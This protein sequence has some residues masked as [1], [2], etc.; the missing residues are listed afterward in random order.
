[1]MKSL[2]FFACGGH[3]LGHMTYK[4]TLQS[5]F[6]EFIPKLPLI[7]AFIAKSLLGYLGAEILKIFRLRRAFTGQYD[8][9]ACTS[10]PVFEFI[11]KLP[12]I[13]AFIVKYLLGYLCAEILK[14]FRLRRAFSGPYD[15]QACT[16]VP[17]FEF[18]PKLPLILAFIVKSLLGYF[19][20]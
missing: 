11:P 12:L 6:I 5:Q 14:I 3:L 10:V 2:R 19:V 1:M 9:Q 13:L 17:V 4:H 8:L 18:I 15:P 16:S 7:L 20:C